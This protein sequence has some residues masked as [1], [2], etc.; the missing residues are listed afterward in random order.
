MSETFSERV[1]AEKK[2]SWRAAMP[3][4]TLPWKTTVKR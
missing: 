3:V 2:T 1:V 4:E